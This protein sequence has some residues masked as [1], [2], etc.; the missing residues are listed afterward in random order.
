LRF[1]AES[2]LAG[3]HDWRVAGFYWR[4]PQNPRQGGFA[5]RILLELDQE[6]SPVLISILDAAGDYFKDRQH[7]PLALCCCHLLREG[8]LFASAIRGRIRLFSPQKTDEGVD[9]SCEIGDHD[10]QDHQ[11]KCVGID[12]PQYVHFAPPFI[13]NFVSCLPPYFILFITFLLP[14]FCHSLPAFRLSPK[15]AV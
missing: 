2:R 1:P 8:L 12:D 9:L 5:G 6:F 15:G 4:G 13:G 7:P 14:F 3:F 10:D 11:Q